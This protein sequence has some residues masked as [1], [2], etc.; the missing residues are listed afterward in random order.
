[1]ES[2]HTGVAPGIMVWASIGFQCHTPLVRIADTLTSQ[3]YISE[4]LKSWSTRTHNAF[5]QSH[6][7]RIVRD[8]MGHAMFKSSSLSIRLN[9]FLG[10]ACSPNLMPIESVWSML[11]KD[12]LFPNLFVS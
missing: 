1:M 7:N 6:S 4:V 2:R 3:R 12:Q 10:L 8:H 5:H 9:C 11:A